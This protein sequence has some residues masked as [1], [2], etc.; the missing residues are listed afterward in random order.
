MTEEIEN[1]KPLPDKWIETDWKNQG[2]VQESRGRI[3][4]T[5]ITPSGWV[6]NRSMDSE[7]WYKIPIEERKPEEKKED[8]RTG[9]KHQRSSKPRATKGARVVRK[10]SMVRR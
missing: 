2:L 4:Y 7:E 8:D 6:R 10:R 5:E 3:W 1:T 9:R